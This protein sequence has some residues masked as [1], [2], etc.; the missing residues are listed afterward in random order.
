MSPLKIESDIITNDSQWFIEG[1]SKARLVSATPNMA[2]TIAY[3]ARVSSKNQENK[4]FKQL[5]SYC[6]RNAHWSVFEQGAVTVEVVTP[7]AIAVQLIRHRSFTFQHFSGRYQDQKEVGKLTEGINLDSPIKLFYLPPKVRLQ[8]T[9][10]RQNSIPTDDTELNEITQLSFLRVYK[11]ALEEY[12]VL[13]DL[14]V[15][16]EMA[17]FVLPQGVYTR[18]Y[19]TGSPR[20]FIHYFG[21]RDVE[22]V[23]QAEHIDLARAIKRCLIHEIPDLFQTIYAE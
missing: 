9:K 5:L 10:N 14:G 6:M 23:V 18:L 21:A 20:S 7:L 16:K 22:N 12:N 2:Q 13:L 11:A 4:N 15:A 17:R 3:I 19:V 8:D 1:D